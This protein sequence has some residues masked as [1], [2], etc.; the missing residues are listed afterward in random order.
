MFVTAGTTEQAEA[1]D[2]I[3][4]A[5]ALAGID[6]AAAADG[7]VV[8]GVPVRIDVVLRAHPTPADLAVLSTAATD[9]PVVVVADRISEAG[10]DT[11]RRAGWGWWDRRGHL[12]VWTTGLRVETP[13][14]TVGSTGAGRGTGTNLWTT[15]GLELALHALIHPDSPVTAR[16]VAPEIGRSVG[17]TQ[18]MV[19]RFAEAGLVGPRTRRPLLPELFWETA[20]HW[21][22]KDWTSVAATAA[23]LAE[24]VGFG[25]AVRVDARAATLGGAR[26]AAAGDQPQ[27]FYLR[28]DAAV[29]KARALVDSDRPTGCWVR[30]SPIEWIPLNDDH[31]AD[32]AH[33][34]S[35]AHPLLCAVRLAAD[36][37]RGREIV[38]DWGIVPGGDQA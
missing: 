38:E 32:A 26:I 19:G 15:V 22:D 14:T 12:R 9:R 20:A 6:A 16:R 25:E 36:P 17:A 27:R 11:L 10:R 3:A 28:G 18:E 24:R 2:E 4:D 37:S 21:P 31:P 34:W 1:L 13:V 8:D 33:P 7:L 5:L 23:E 29:R 35:V 30:R